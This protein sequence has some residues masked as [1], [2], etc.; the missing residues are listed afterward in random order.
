MSTKQSKYFKGL[1][2]M[3]MA[4]PHKAGETTIVMFTHVFT[5]TIAT[6]DIL[7]LIPMPVNMKLVAFDYASE[8]IGAIN[9]KAG[10]MTGSVGD[11][12]SVRTLGAELFAATPA[13]TPNEAPLLAILGITP[14]DTPRAIGIAPD[15]NIT[16]GATKKLHVR[17]TFVS[18]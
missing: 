4:T 2:R 17:M 9:L 1:G 11:T 18:A 16:A 8:N 14:S 12:T 5:E 6:T 3:P 13:A 7:E 15:A 10:L